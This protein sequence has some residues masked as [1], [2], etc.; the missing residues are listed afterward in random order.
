MVRRTL[1]AQW[2]PHLETRMLDNL[3]SYRAEH[4]AQSCPCADQ[5]IE[6]AQSRR[7]RVAWW[8]KRFVREGG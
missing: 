6:I 8:V 3:L 1:G 5:E 7:A 4:P 2:S